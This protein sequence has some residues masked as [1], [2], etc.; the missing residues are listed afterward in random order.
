MTYFITGLPRSRT[1]WC[2]NYLTT[3]GHYCRHD[4]IGEV[5]DIAKLPE[6]LGDDNVADPGV[7]MTWKKIAEIFDEPKFVIIDRP[8][9]EVFH[10]SQAAFSDFTG[11]DPDQIYAFLDSLA[12]AGSKLINSG[13]KV[14]TIEYHFFDPRILW[15]FCRP[16]DPYDDK[17][18]ALLEQL[19]VENMMYREREKQIKENVAV[20]MNSGDMR[21]H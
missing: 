8:I 4:V 3:P 20:L 1:G 21:V 17:R 16:N 14:L 10:A 11:K 9:E 2:A 12:E 18:T 5:D 6:H 7:L 13:E 19:R 15:D